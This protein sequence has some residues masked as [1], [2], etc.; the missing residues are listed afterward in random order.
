MRRNPT[1]TQW[2][3]PE[4]HDSGLLRLQQEL[5]F[6]SELHFRKCFD[7]TGGILIA[8]TTL[9]LALIIG[10]AIISHL[11]PAKAVGSERGIIDRLVERIPLQSMKIIIIVWQ[12][13]TQVRT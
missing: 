4:M 11:I 7:R 10:F 9:I 5:H 1:H 3:N 8:T 13:L 12:I 2:H 6:R